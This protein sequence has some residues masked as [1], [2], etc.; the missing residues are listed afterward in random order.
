LDDALLGTL[1]EGEHKR[2]AAVG[3]R[4]VPPREHCGNVDIKNFSRG[5]R[6]YLLV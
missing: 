6:V 4:T 2:V 3:C 1:P 5:A